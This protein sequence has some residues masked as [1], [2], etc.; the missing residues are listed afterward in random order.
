MSELAGLATEDSVFGVSRSLSGRAWRFRPAPERVVTAL[1]QRH[2]LPDVVARLLAGRGV[3]LDAA[4]DYLSPS[5][6]ALMPDPYVLRDM[7]KAAERIA[8]AIRNGE[9]VAVFGDYD[10]DGATSAA[11]LKRFF[12][13]IGAPLRTYIPDRMAEGYGPNIPALLR[14]REEGV[15]LVITVDCGAL[16]FEPLRAAREAGLD[17]VVLDHH[18]C[19]PALPEAVAVVNPNRI[20]DDS[21]LGFLAAVGVVFLLV[22][23]VNRLLRECGHYD[24]RR[25]PPLLDYLDLVALGTVADVVPLQGLNRAFVTQGIKVLG[26]ARNPGLNALM[27]VAR[28]TEPPGSYHLGFLLGPR[29]N[30]GGRVGQAGLGTEL[31]ATDDAALAEKIAATLDRHN[32]ERQAIESQVLEEALHQLQIRHGGA[33]AGALALAADDGWHPG[34]IGIVAGR[35]KERF[36]LPSVVI[37]FDGEVGKGS[38]RSIAGVDL[39]AAVTAARQAGLLIN[40]GGHKMAAGLTVARDRLPDLEQFLQ[41]RLREQVAAAQEARALMLDGALSVPACSIELAEQIASA[42]PYG[43]GNPAPRFA[44]ARL[45]VAFADVVGADHVRATFESACGSRIKGIA[46]RAAATPMGQRLIGS[47]GQ[48]FH[49]AGSLRVNFWNGRRSTE[50]QIEDVAEV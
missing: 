5:L 6:R 9:K 16:S 49:V 32:A 23:A 15:S 1:M 22:V 50:M 35:I 25:E 3:D 27:K 29:V 42:G 40:G 7:D 21:G 13:S 17:V 19:E 30:A 8:A 45:K 11:L 43:A 2:G 34:V 4:A 33:P 38:A 36:D 48:H 14:L 31:L 46:F 37:A 44:F 26:Q 24:G 20:D 39:G 18:I 47:M 12:A 10:V 41:D 28:I